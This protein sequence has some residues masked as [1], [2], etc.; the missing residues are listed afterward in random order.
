MPW[1]E[2][3]NKYDVARK[4]NTL[5]REQVIKVGTPGF[6]INRISKLFFVCLEAIG[7]ENFLDPTYT[8][9]LTDKKGLD[10]KTAANFTVSY[11]NAML[12]LSNQGRIDD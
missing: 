4:L 2:K 9:Y 1:F 7:K 5:L 3:K 11:T 6:D 8:E 12:M 10:F